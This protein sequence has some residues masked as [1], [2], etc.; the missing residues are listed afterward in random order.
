MDI[1]CTNI[2]HKIDTGDHSPIVIRQRKLPMRLEE[3]IEKMIADMLENGII[4][5]SVSPWSFPLVVV[6]KKDKSLR[7]CV[8]Y[9]LLNKI[10]NKP[11][12]PI[13]DCRDL[14]DTISGA[15]YFSALDLSSGYHQ[16]PMHET[17]K[18]KTA[19]CTRSG[20]YKYNRMPFG[21]AGAPFSFQR[22]MNINLREENYRSCLIYLDDVLVF[23]KTKEEHNNRLKDVLQKFRDAGVKLS[24]GKCSLLKDEI[25]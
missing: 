25:S 18:C 6:R 13:P 5:K 4:R 8:D 22:I 10:T 3:E 21:L 23:G 24:P 12:Y 11:I 16:V 14:F 20:Q 19:F 15:K 17:D 9:R 2:T 1:G 7:L